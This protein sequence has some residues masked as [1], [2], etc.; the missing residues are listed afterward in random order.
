MIMYHFTS[1]YNLGNVG[2]ENIMAAG[3]KAHPLDWP[4]LLGLNGVWLTSSPDV[5]E[6]LSGQYEARIKV[7]IPSHDRKLI[8]LYRYLRKR[9]SLEAIAN[10]D[11]VHGGAW[12]TFYVYTGDIPLSRIQAIEYANADK[13]AKIEADIRAGKVK[14]EELIELAA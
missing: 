8:H 14:P 13:R 9:L 7:I 3:L 1:L 2:P 10:L 5:P 12:R 4:D 6:G 11:A